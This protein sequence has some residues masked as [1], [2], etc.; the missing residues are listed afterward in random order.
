MP[1]RYSF[2]AMAL[3]ALTT[4]GAFGESAPMFGVYRV[5]YPATHIAIMTEGPVIDGDVEEI[6]RAHV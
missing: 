6:G 2:L 3:V 4:L 1:L 5:V